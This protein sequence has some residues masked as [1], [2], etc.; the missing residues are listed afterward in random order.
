[1]RRMLSIGALVI[2]MGL[3]L[4]AGALVWQNQTQEHVAQETSQAVVEEFAQQL[5]VHSEQII[6]A[7]SVEEVL[8]ETEPVT[9]VNGEQ[10]LGVLSLPDLNLTLPVASTWDYSKLQ[11]TPCRLD[12]TVEEGTLIIAAHNYAAHFGTIGTLE[13]GAEAT[14]LDA[15]GVSHQYALVAQELLAE[16]DVEGLATGQW[17]LTLFTCYYGDNSQRVVLR[18]VTQD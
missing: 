5:V 13:L 18:F 7:R 14:F 15:A 12:G 8:E 11:T 6:V 16:E 10:Y 1:M 2:G 4:G 9:E 3:M 17:D